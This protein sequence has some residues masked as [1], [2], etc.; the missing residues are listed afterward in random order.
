MSA[1][2]KALSEQLAMVEQS[3]KAAGKVT[4]GVY[5]TVQKMKGMVEKVQVH[6][7][8][9]SGFLLLLTAADLAG[10]DVRSLSQRSRRPT[11]LIRNW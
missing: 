11:G 6:L 3:V 7:L 1:P 10:C 4:P 8:G 5:A 9:K 2:L